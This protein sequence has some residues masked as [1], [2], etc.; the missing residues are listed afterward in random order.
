M[1]TILCNVAMQVIQNIHNYLAGKSKTALPK[2]TYYL[3]STLAKMFL[4]AL[5]DFNPYNLTCHFNV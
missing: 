3:S 4:N 2:S 5:L 1:L